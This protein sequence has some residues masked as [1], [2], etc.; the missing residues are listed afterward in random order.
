M[1]KGW[2]HV[3][4]A[5]FLWRA[6]NLS[7]IAKDVLDVLLFYLNSE[8]GTAWPS[9]QT[10][11]EHTGASKR[12]ISRAIQEL[13]DLKVI[14]SW[15][16]PPTVGDFAGYSHKVLIYGNKKLY[17]PINIGLSDRKLDKILKDYLD[18]RA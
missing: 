8:T 14:K 9:Y 17:P 4:K 7:P 11:K 10:I 12:S 16:R 3:T 6:G 5:F 1:S 15:R 13:Q 2:L 18:E